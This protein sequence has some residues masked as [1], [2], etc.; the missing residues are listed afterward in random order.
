MREA[1][2]GYE[3]SENSP[4]GRE[5]VHAK[6]CECPYTM[7]SAKPYAGGGTACFNRGVERDD[8]R[9][10]AVVLAAL[11]VGSDRPRFR[12]V[13]RAGLWFFFFVFFFFF[14]PGS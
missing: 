4:L 9:H 12:P 10:A 14:Y 11:A 8:V 2:L 5:A 3:Y 13:G 7:A 1:G 6:P